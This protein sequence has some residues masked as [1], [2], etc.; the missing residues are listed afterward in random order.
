MK[1]PLSFAAGVTGLRKILQKT[2][3]PV[4]LVAATAVSVRAEVTTGHPDFE[5]IKAETTNPDSHYYY[6]KLLKE[7]MSNDTIMTDDDYHYFY[8]GTMF[9]EDYNPYREN[10]YQKEVEATKPLYFKQENLTKAECRQIEQLAQ[11]SLD[12]NPLDLTQMTYRVYVYEKNRKF[13]HAKIWKKKLDSILLVIARSGTGESPEK[14]RVVV[15]PINEFEFFNLSGGAV[16]S[17]EFQEPY[18][19]KLEVVNRKSDKTTTNY[20]DLREMLEQYYLKHPEEQ[21]PDDAPSSTP[22]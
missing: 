13:N 4:L 15:Y 12:N 9:Q 11:K 1:N 2:I 21:T 6:P 8:Y 19:D 5:K 22:D 16:K 17:Q 10:P 14:A 3:L 7:F 20:F 18:Y